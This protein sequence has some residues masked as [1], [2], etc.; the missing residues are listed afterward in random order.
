MSLF[1]FPSNLYIGKDGTLGLAPNG[2]LFGGFDSPTFFENFVAPCDNAS[3]HV[4]FDDSRF[5]SSLTNSDINTSGAN[6][7]IRTSS[8][9]APCRPTLRFYSGDTLIDQL[10]PQPFNSGSGL[11]FNVTT[12]PIK[13]LRISVTQALPLA[14][15]GSTITLS[16]LKARM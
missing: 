16:V 4:F 5:F 7:F 9:I 14:D 15:V 3:E 11:Y 12:I 1:T 2:L 10:T 8:S 6:I 13:D